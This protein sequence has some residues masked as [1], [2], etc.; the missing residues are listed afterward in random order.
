MKKFILYVASVLLFSSASILAAPV[1]GVAG[2][3]TEGQIDVKIE[4]MTSN[5]DEANGVGS[6]YLYLSNGVVV[7]VPKIDRMNTTLAIAAFVAKKPVTI[8]NYIPVVNNGGGGDNDDGSDATSDSTITGGQ[9]FNIE[10]SNGPD[11]GSTTGNGASNTFWKGPSIGDGVTQA[12]LR[13]HRID[14]LVK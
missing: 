13:V 5:D 14:V 4:S 12:A 8:W 11:T 9:D 2:S 3:G 7:H 10:K 1:E 6:T